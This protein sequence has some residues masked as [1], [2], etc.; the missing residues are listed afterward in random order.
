MKFPN[1]SLIIYLSTIFLIAAISA[2]VSYFVSD[3]I[4]LIKEKENEQRFGVVTSTGNFPTS[5]TNAQDNDLIN[6]GDFN[7]LEYVIGETGTTS[8]KTLTYQVVNTNANNVNFTGKLTITSATTTNHT[9]TNLW[10]TTFNPTNSSTTNATL[11]NFWSTN[12]QITNAS[13]TDLTVSGASFFGT[14]TST[15]FYVSGGTRLGALNVINNTNLGNATTT[16]LTVQGGT[17]LGSLD[18][19]ALNT[20]TVITNAN[21]VNSTISGISLGSNLADLT[22]TNGT[23]TFSGTYN[24]ST[25][26]TI[27]LNLGSV[28]SWTGG[29]TFLNATSTASQFLPYGTLT[30]TQGGQV[31]V[32]SNSNKLQFNSNGVTQ[33]LTATSSFSFTVASTTASENITLKRFSQAVTIQK[34]SCVNQGGSSPSVTYN[35]PHGT[36]RTSGTNLFTSDEAMTNT[37]TGTQIYTFA[38]ATLAAGEVMW[39]TTS[40]QSG[41]A[42]FFGCT[43]YWFD[44]N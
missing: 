31:Q 32:N 18:I 17:K 13:T 39:L 25:A 9:I 10:V 5:L 4:V 27:G 1:K 38:D 20:A 26:R 35:L 12:G 6:A 22:A 30:L 21:L 24:G 41:A 29:Q 44:D 16:G 28:N 7:H 23:L 42:G 19:A 43:V 37:T 33:V 36:N 2:G 8:P 14:A 40:A 3:Q 34:V 11:T 15:S